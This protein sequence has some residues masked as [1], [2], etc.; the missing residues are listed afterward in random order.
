M[1]KQDADWRRWKFLL[2]FVDVYVVTR[3]NIFSVPFPIW[4]KSGKC[5]HHCFLVILDKKK[6][7]QHIYHDVYTLLLRLLL[8]QLYLE[9]K[10]IPKRGVLKLGLSQN[11]AHFYCCFLLLFKWL[12]LSKKKFIQIALLII[13]SFWNHTTIMKLSSSVWIE[14]QI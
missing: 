14:W 9:T 1:H 2:N 11:Y 3:M 10:E 6:K 8:S 13:L 7:A 4:I 12:I 5:W